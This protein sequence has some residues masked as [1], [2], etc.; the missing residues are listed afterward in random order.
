MTL[1]EINTLATRLRY[2]LI[3]FE[4]D[5][6]AKEAIEIIDDI[7]K[8]IKDFK[9]QDKIT[10]TQAYGDYDSPIRIS[11]RTKNLDIWQRLYHLGGGHRQFHPKYCYDNHSFAEIMPIVFKQ[12]MF[13][14]HYAEGQT[15]TWEEVLVTA[16][17]NAQNEER[18]IKC[19]KL[20]LQRRY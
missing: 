12:I 10:I 9:L 14:Q 6:N 20:G 4:H 16:E 5:N 8:T 7:T 3:R 19:K 18:A 15:E 2:C 13:L 1:E 17:V 11:L